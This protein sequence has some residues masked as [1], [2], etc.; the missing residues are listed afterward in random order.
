MDLPPAPETTETTETTEAEPEES[1]DDDEDDER[2]A[3]TI[4]DDGDRT[5]ALLYGL[6][7]LAIVLA[8]AAGLFLVVA[9]SR[10]D[11][12]DDAVTL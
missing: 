10:R 11:E 4:A 1:D 2:A 5:S 9:R 3:D 7:A 6:G 12:E 8:T